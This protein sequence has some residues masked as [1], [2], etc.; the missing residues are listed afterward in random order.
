[1]KNNRYWYIGMILLF[2]AGFYL[3]FTV[4]SPLNHIP[5]GIPNDYYDII[6][7][8]EES[9]Y[10]LYV[11]SD[12][13]DFNHDYAAINFESYDALSQSG[14]QN[15]NVLVIDMDKFVD[16]EFTTE[17]NIINLYQEQCYHVIIVN[18]KSSNSSQ[19]QDLIEPEYYDY[20][21]ITLTYDHCHINHY[22]QVINND[23]DSNQF[24]MYAILDETHRI[25]SK[26]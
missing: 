7:D 2:I 13:I 6:S 9:D 18:Y 8:I 22:S 3:L 17:D 4:L 15:Q 1:M 23:F 20:D 21:F 26:S 14:V 12:T 19:L 25:I 10:N 16:N 5:E 24:L 11:Y